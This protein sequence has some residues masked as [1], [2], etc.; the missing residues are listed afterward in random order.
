MA[1]APPPGASYADSRGSGGLAGLPCRE[2]LLLHRQR[3]PTHVPGRRKAGSRDRRPAWSYADSR[4]SGV[5]GVA[6]R[7]RPPGPPAV[8]QPCARAPAGGSRTAARRSY[9]DARGAGSQRSPGRES[10][11]C[12][13][14]GGPPRRAPEGGSPR[15][16]RRVVRRLA[17]E[18]RPRQLD[19][20][21][22]QRGSRAR[23]PAVVSRLFARFRGFLEPRTSARAS[24]G[25]PTFQ[26]R[27]KVAHAPPQQVSR[28]RRSSAI[29]TISPKVCSRS[30]AVVSSPV[31]MWSE[32]VQI[33]ERAAAV[34]GG[35]G[36][37]RARLH[38]DREHAVRHHLRRAARDGR[39]R[40]VAGED[41]AD[42]D[43][44]AL[45]GLGRLDRPAEQAEVC[46]G[47]V[48]DAVEGD[49]V[50]RGVGARAGGDHDVAHP[51]ASVTAPHEPTRTTDCTS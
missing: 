28:A 18:R 38:L 41:Q 14:S 22:G 36:V 2:P 42:V 30:W 48:V 11:S 3:W 37:E 26:R 27:R 45:A 24:G 31:T 7:E 15:A 9:A 40:R 21:D 35:E 29:S 47:G 13:A 34:L 19:R 46:D 10:S 43:G 8:A 23:C 25:P 6:V 33:A 50:H 49:P 20:A 1:H 16:A 5:L 17:R 12:T 32:T 39:G 51:D 44:R 4:G